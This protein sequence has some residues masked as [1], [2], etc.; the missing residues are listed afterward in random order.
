MV[1]NLAWPRSAIYDLTG[2]TW[3][4]KWSALLFIGLTLLV[5]AGIHWRTRIR[6]GGADQLPQLRT[7]AAD[8][9]AEAAA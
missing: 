3:W 7:S 5:G 8:S 2:H 6:H 1:I 9:R 4:L